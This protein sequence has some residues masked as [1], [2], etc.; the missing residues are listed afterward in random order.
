MLE[1]FAQSENA[2]K[3]ADVAEVA[4]EKGF[5]LT[6]QVVMAAAL[7][8]GG[9]LLSRLAAKAIRMRFEK[10]RGFD[11]TL[12]PILAQTASYIILILT[13]VMVLSHFGIEPTSIIAVL[14]AAGLA[15]G[16]ALQGTLQNVAA[17][18]MLLII[19]PFRRGDYISAGSAE[20]TV[21]EIG[22]FMTRLATAQ[23]LF[24]AVPN[25]NIWSS[26]II[27]YTRNPSR[28]LDLTI[29]ISYDADI[30]KARDIILDIVKNDERLQTSPEPIVVV[31]NLGD[32]SIDLEL[33]AWAARPDYWN[34]NFDT[35]RAIKLALD[36]AGISIPYPHRQVVLP[37]Q[38]IELFAQKRQGDGRG[39]G[40]GGP[41]NKASRQKPARDT[42]PR[43]GAKRR[44][45]AVR[46]DIGR[47]SEDD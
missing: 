20:G 3:F 44:K 22:L 6:L 45:G 12:T 31:R 24:V 11:Q 18:I 9:Y 34:F 4:A 43:G 29:G 25:S 15:I 33:R 8:I 42:T 40:K 17:G 36:E 2:K 26:V 21:D 14:G 27:N 35:T 38:M 41:G 47:T 7:L 37:P 13:F 28:R 23:G 19:R 1:A 30:D 32:S 16:L 5:S 46:G 39:L 10:I